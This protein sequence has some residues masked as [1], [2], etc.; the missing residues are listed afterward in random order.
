MNSRDLRNQIEEYIEQLSPD[1]LQ[2]AAD[3]LA[4]LL[5]RESH[6]ATEELLQIPGFLE[7]FERAKKDVLAGKLTDWRNIRNDV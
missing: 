3:F 4:Y 6:E 1:R 2:V 7:E 5:E